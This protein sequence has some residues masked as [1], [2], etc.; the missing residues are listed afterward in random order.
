MAAADAPPAAPAAA[1][2]GDAARSLTVNSLGIMATTVVNA[3]LGYGYWTLA[4]RI[5]P[6][7]QVGLGSAATSALVVISLV[8]HLGSGTGLIARLPLRDSPAQW[9]L[10]VTAT[11]LATMAATLLVAA[12]TVLP[13]GHAVAPLRVLTADPVFALWFVFGAVGWT[14]SG[15]LD[16][17]FIAERRTSLMLLRNTATAVV[18]LVGLV[19]AALVQPSAG[20]G[21]VVATWALSGLLGTLAG[22]A[23]CR[24]CLPGVGRVPLRAAA[25]ELALLA[26]PSVGHHAVSV[27]G[28]VPTY[29]LPVVV[30]ARLGARANATFF[31]TWMIGS[32]IF[33]IS[34][35]VSSAL[36]AEGSH[37]RAGLRRMSLRSLGVTVAAVAAPAAVLCAVG[38]LVLSLFGAGYRAGYPLLVALVLSAFPDAVSNVA[39]ATLRVRG[40][41][42]RAAALNTTIAVT[43]VAGAWFTTPHLG[44]LGAGLSWLGA[45]LLGALVV[46]LLR[47]VL[48]P[49]P[50][51]PTPVS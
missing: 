50:D 16:Y 42:A 3:G 18:K 13:L 4:A 36:F 28:L 14:G 2:A 38:T 6:A 1:R 41:L 33:M 17:V 20:A 39:V 5:M 27:A 49:P 43:A 31:I 48:L 25:R 22:L 30:T 45:Q 21:T 34:P 8:V 37:R 10:T 46:L 32:A 47:A 7:S 23:L 29:L 15:V 40:L 11:L 26:R 44:I 51:H 35:A 12:A 24:R 9:R 19:L